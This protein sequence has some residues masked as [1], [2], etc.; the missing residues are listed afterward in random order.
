ME[1]RFAQLKVV[2]TNM[3]ASMK[4]NTFGSRKGNDWKNGQSY[5]SYANLRFLYKV[6]FSRSMALDEVMPHMLYKRSW[7]MDN[8]SWRP[9]YGFKC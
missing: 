1:A 2:I 4:F 3:A 5:G 8:R 6:S 9:C 7:V